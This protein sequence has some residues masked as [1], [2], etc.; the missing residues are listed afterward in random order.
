[1][2]KSQVVFATRAEANRDQEIQTQLE[3][4]VALIIFNRPT[5]TAQVLEAISKA[6]PK[7]LLVIGDGPRQ[8]IAGEADKVSGCRALLERIDWPCQVLTNFSD[9][10]LGCRDRVS[11]GLNWVFSIVK[12]AIILEDDCVPSE[13]FFRFT[14]ELLERYRAD[15]RV[16][17]ISGSSPN[18]IS[19]SSSESY[20]YSNFPAI[21]GWATWARVWNKYDASIPNWPNMERLG[22]LTKVLST[23]RAIDFWKS[24]LDDVYSG[25]IDT[26]DY[27]LA[28][29]HWTEGYFS[30]VPSKNLV[31]NI[32]FGPDAT[33]TLDRTSVHANV[34]T[35]ELGF[36]LKHPAAVTRNAV[37]DQEIEL[38]KFAQS[39][40]LVLVTKLFNA[41]PAAAQKIIR[42]GYVRFSK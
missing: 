33:H 35:E 36:P 8:Q 13:D 31:S 26:W 30:I 38:S 40:S 15:E 19:M 17:S 12:E 37:R 24:A 23:K 1:M 42:R 9:N 11:S 27:Q 5:Q 6:R 2:F 4:P 16:G 41:L 20:F 25:K 7:V 10:N 22:I 28:L 14:S 39:G 32:G 18:A 3:T 21:W 34:K 29:L